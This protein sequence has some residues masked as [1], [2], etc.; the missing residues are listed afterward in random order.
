[1]NAVAKQM[2][3]WCVRPRFVLSV[4]LMVL[5]LGCGGDSS[6]NLP[7]PP[8]FEPPPEDDGSMDSLVP[9]RENASWNEIC[10]HFL[11][12]GEDCTAVAKKDYE[13]GSGF[14]HMY[15][16][17]L[18]D[19]FEPQLS[20]FVDRTDLLEASADVAEGQA[21]EVT[22]SIQKPQPTVKDARQKHP[23]ASYTVRMIVWGSSVNKALV[24]DSDGNHFVV[25]KD[26]PLGNNN[27]RVAN[28]TEWTVEVV[29]DDALDKIVLSMEPRLLR[30]RSVDL[31]GVEPSTIH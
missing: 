18:R 30:G 5:A 19:P 14:V 12:K 11:G 16:R 7:P 3:R 22:E 2:E 4:A 21:S 17:N 15:G 29:E 6:S 28:I 23:A 10:E 25:T 27:G 13:P 26:E 24:E 31:S 8:P 20:K 9:E 1:M